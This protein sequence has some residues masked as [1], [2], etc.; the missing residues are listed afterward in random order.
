MIAPFIKPT[1]MVCQQ[2]TT[3]CCLSSICGLAFRGSRP[4]ERKMAMGGP[5]PQTSSDDVLLAM[6]SKKRAN[7]SGALIDY[8]LLFGYLIWRAPCCQ[9]VILDAK[10][11]TKNNMPRRLNSNIQ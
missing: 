6:L 1:T 11:I 10:L 3:C 4:K 2:V 9:A 7:N 8:E 5:R